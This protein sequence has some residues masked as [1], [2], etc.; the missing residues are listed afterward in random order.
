MIAPYRLEIARKEFV[1]AMTLDVD[2]LAHNWSL[3]L[4]RGLAGIV[5]GI[6]T[7]LAPGIS[8]AVLVLLYGA[9]ALADGLLSLL[10]AMRPRGSER[11]GAMLVYGVVGIG[12]GVVALLWPA[13]TAFALVYLIAAWALVTGVVEVAAAVRLR[14]VIANEWLLAVSGLLSVGL[15]VLLMLYP[16]SGALVLVLWVGAYALVSGVVLTVLAFRL[17]SWSEGHH[18]PHAAHGLA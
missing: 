14:K 17:H 7:L 15:G 11:S 6:L 16:I 3:V 5:F 1:M 12:A 4:L 2:T 9:Y 13:I 18:S 8:L 10:A